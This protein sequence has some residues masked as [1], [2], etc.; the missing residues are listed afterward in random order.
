MGRLHYFGP[1]DDPDG[2]LQRYL[3]Q[4]DDLYAGRQPQNKREGL[5]VRDLVNQ[6]LSSKKANV[7]SGELVQATWRDYYVTC[8]R[9][10]ATFGANRLVEDLRGSD[11]DQFRRKLSK[12]NGLV[13]I[14]NQVTH[15]RMLFHYAYKARLVDRP[16]HFGADFARPSAKAI[17]KQRK[18]RMFEASEIHRILD[19]AGIVMKAMVLLGVNC[20][21]GPADIGRLPSSALNLEAGWLQFPRP[22]TGTERRIPLWPETIDALRQALEIRP[23]PASEGLKDLVFL[24]NRGGS[25]FKESTRY[26]SEQVGEFLKSIDEQAEKEAKRQGIEPPAKLYRLGRGFYALRHV[27]ETIGG[28]SCDQVA[29]DAI[30]GHERGDMASHYRER[31]SDERLQRVVDTVHQWLYAEHADDGLVDGDEPATVPFRVVS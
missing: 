9:V 19:H 20:A 27:S 24:T 17:R 21:F 5:T 16:V 2:A 15:T 29:V 4:R 11:F 18:P 23:E 7:D 26:L 14:R 12:T 13:G 6:F 22:K 30:M 31:V 3:D 1:W 28:E 25:W 8:K 10:I